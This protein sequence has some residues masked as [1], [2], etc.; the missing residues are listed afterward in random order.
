MHGV[1]PKGGD[2]WDHAGYPRTI[3]WEF[4]KSELSG[5]V[6]TNRT[7]KGWQFRQI[8]KMGMGIFRVVPKH[9]MI[10]A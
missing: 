6:T 7:F 10:S 8:F 5:G 1:S 2:D 4:I 9:L 3:F